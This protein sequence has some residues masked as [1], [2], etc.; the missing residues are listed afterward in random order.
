MSDEHD[1]HGQSLA[2]WVCVGILIV[3]FAIGSWAVVVVSAPLAIAAVVLLVVGL[4]AGKVLAAAGHGVAGS[5][6]R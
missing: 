2:A 4:I 1:N 6:G 3:A 5:A